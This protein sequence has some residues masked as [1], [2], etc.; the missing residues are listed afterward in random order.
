MRS[1]IILLFFI[2]TTLSVAQN[3]VPWP[4]TDSLQVTFLKQDITWDWQGI[5]QYS[6]NPINGPGFFFFDIFNSNLL[7]PNRTARKWRDEN[8][9]DG[10]IFYKS[11]HAYHGLYLKSWHLAD[12]QLQNYT[13]YGNHAAGFK[14]IYNLPANFSLG[15]Y[16]G[17]QRSQNQKI[18]EWGWDLGITAVGKTI[19]LGS[20]QGDLQA[21]M[22]YDFYD[23]RKNSNIGL[24]VDIKAKFS[25][26]AR[27]SIAV[28]YLNDNQQ[29]FSG[30][31]DEPVNVHIEN[32]SLYNQLQYL[33][34]K[35]S[36]L[37]LAT[38][39]WYRTILDELPGDINKRNVFRFENRLA[40]RHYSQWLMVTLGANTFQEN[41][42]NLRIS[43]DS[44][45][46]QTG[47]FSDVVFQLGAKNSLDIQFNLIKFQYD[48]PD[49]I[50]NND[51]R[52]ELRFIGSLRY[53]HEFSP[54]LRT[55]LEA[56]ANLFHKIYIFNEQSANNNWNRIYRLSAFVYYHYRNW[57]NVLNTAVLANYTVYDF[58]KMFSSPRSFIFRKYY[59]SDSLLIPI[60]SQLDLG[61]YT[62][63]ELEDRGTF[64][65]Q[66]FSQQLVESSQG[67]YYDFFLRFKNLL[68][69]R[70]D[71]GV[72][73]FQWDG[74]RHIPVRKKDRDIERRSPYLRLT[75]PWGHKVKLYGSIST[76]YL[77]DAG[78]QRRTYTTG[79]IIMIYSF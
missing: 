48:T 66:Q 76:N 57:Y 1:Y 7:I 35:R 12:R 44:K 55:Q 60:K 15:P 46:L 4:T 40:W 14:A 31:L 36:T 21:N 75:Y 73:L 10:F 51:D 38:I 65:E 24:T 62:K 25:P 8:R 29:Y 58:E 13:Q 61:L 50:T 22:D 56:Y 43:T 39:L 72:N 41:Q 28:N 2:L 17:Y 30:S 18:I 45:A 54:L 23:R 9:M 70:I 78:R 33:F 69:L 64:F 16:L 52:D 47:L 49:S 68:A 26:Q 5:M 74:W 20:Y 77:N 79:N 53:D 63:I 32:K 27:D 59:F 3:S 42:D 11:I 37:E 19:S 71:A 34:S 6:L 67:Q